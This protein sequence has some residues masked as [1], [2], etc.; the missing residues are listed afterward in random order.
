MKNIYLLLAVLGTVIPVMS[1]LGL[2]HEETPQLLMFFP[3]IFA[4]GWAAGF[5]LDLFISSA[6]F[7]VFMFANASANNGPAPWGFI[8]LNLCIGL[9]LALPLYLYRRAVAIDAV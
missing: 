1:F 3:S 7:W 5:A 4:N 6:A 9:S 8:L 2:F